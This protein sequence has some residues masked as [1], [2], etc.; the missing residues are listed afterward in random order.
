MPRYRPSVGDSRPVIERE[1]IDGVVIPTEP[2]A[3]SLVGDDAWRLLFEDRGLLLTWTKAPH[4][5]GDAWGTA[6]R[7]TS[8]LSQQLGAV[9]SQAGGA[10][11]ASS[12][13]LCR[14]EL[15]T[16][17]TL[18]DLVPAVGGG[19]RGLVRD[20]RGINGHARLH[21]HTGRAAAGVGFAPLL[22]LLAVQVGTEMLARHQQER[23][24]TYIAESVAALRQAREDDMEAR[25]GSVE[26]ALGEASAAMLDRVSI[27]SSIGLGA[28]RTNLREVKER[29]LMWLERWEEAARQLPDTGGVD[30][31]RMQDI[32]AAGG[33]RDDHRQF[34]HRIAMLYRALTLDSRALVVTGAEAALE[35]GDHSLPH[36]HEELARGL[37][38]NAAIQDRLKQLMWDLAAPPITYTFPWEG[39]EAMA[40]DRM[41]SSMANGI[42]RLPEAPALLTERNRQVLEL[43]RR[44]DG[45]VRVLAPRAA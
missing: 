6:L 31:G 35:N 7:G 43:V 24:L 8:A 11:D 45:E 22:G 20:S 38:R 40:L 39:S 44:P 37:Q 21:V 14:L 9:L 10:V 18:R 17:S 34:P 32:L 1:P 33:P 12:G 42:S 13:L 28:A 19:Y 36:L 26:A 16:G 41:L 3:R 23:K 5:T 30:T 2:G 27:P 15:P 25:L 4:S 29:T